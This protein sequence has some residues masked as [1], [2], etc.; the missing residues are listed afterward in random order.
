MSR[1]EREISAL[2]GSE[3]WE[4][5]EKR[6]LHP[7]EYHHRGRRCESRLKFDW[8]AAPALEAAE[9]VSYI[10]SQRTAGRGVKAVVAD[11][12]APIVRVS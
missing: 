4:K 5:R 1:G 12:T 9:V 11:A 6:V 10:Q 8:L 7:P 3:G 2:A